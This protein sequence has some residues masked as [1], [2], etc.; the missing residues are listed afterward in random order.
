MLSIYTWFFLLM[1]ILLWGVGAFFDKI[2][3]MHSDANAA[4]VVREC[5]MAVICIPLLAAHYINPAKIPF[6]SSRTALLYIGLSVLV[7]TAGM[8]FYL[9]ALGGGGEASRIVPLSSVYPLIT[10]LLAVTFLGEKFTWLKFAGT[11]L[12][13]GGVWLLSL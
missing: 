9:K 13:S 3:L 7:T 12:I 2:T 8:Y 4:F 6:T 11:L 5:A 10:V 1:A